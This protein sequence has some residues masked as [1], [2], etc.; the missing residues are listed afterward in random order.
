MVSMPDRCIDQS[1]FVCT[2]IPILSVSG[3]AAVA[4]LVLRLV[5]KRCKDRLEDTPSTDEAGNL[6]RAT[7]LA[8]ALSATVTVTVWTIAVLIV[9][10]YLNVSLAP[11]I[12]SAGIAGVAL[13]FGA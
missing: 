6:Q 1:W 13:G 12:A 2:G 3:A 11:L 8:H 10:G 9:L 7:T 4:T 5:V